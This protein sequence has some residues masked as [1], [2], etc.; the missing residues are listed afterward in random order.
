M[1]HSPTRAQIA[2][3]LLLGLLW[4]LNWPTVKI[5]LAEIG[6]WTLRASA[7]S[8]AGLTL[9]GFTCARGGTL[10][11]RPAH[12][13]RIAVPAVLT[14]AAPNV[15][16][17]HAQLFAPTGRIAVVVF[18]M[19]V[20]ATILA[21][22][23]LGERL[24]PRRVLGLA[25]GIAGLIALGWPLVVAG[26]FSFGLLLAL[27][28]ALCWAAG[29]IFFKRFPSEATPLAFA[30]WQLL[31]GAGCAAAGMLLVEGLP[32]PRA[33]SAPTV[34]AFAYHAL[35]GQALATVLWFEVVTR[36]PAGT[37]ALG[38]LTVPA[39]GVASATIFLG[40]RPTPADLAGL[41]LIVAAASTVLL[42][43]RR[44]AKGS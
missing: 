38:T 33:F 44:A 25:L 23:V 42:P 10:S 14:I 40:E 19:P 2:L 3:V 31:I 41:V 20:W 35:L 21:R 32:A 13:W 1:Q 26:E 34:L 15:L 22:L 6:P 39:V 5:A 27:L 12:W 16:I 29:T 30:T 36:I 8:I 7:L 37:A 43:G 9:V 4:G 28:A 24:D 18:T 11:V 17:A